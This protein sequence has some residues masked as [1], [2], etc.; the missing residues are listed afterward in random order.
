MTPDDDPGWPHVLSILA[1]LVPGVARSQMRKPTGTEHGLLVLR[2]AFLSFSVALVLFGV[3][4]AFLKLARGSVLPWVPLIV[5]VAIASVVAPRILEQPLD[6]STDATLAESYRTRFFLRLAFVESV[7]LFGF[8]FSFIGGG[9]WIYYAAAAFTLLRFW[10]QAPPT[11]SGLAR[12]QEQLN[13]SGCGRS[14][15]GALGGAGRP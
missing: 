14:L 4:L 1:L 8:F 13:A 7:A 6:C 15:L 11:R 2:R 5:A 12:E 9:K 10:T 3:V